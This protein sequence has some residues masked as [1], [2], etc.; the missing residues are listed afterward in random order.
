MII[1]I[2]TT[3]APNE[4]I[5]DP[6]VRSQ[7][8]SNCWQNANQLA[9]AFPSCA[10]YTIVAAAEAPAVIRASITFT[11]SFKHTSLIEQINSSITF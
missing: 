3:T 11:T 6:E 7:K 9:L 10:K 4:P 8:E 5:R 1:S 2:N